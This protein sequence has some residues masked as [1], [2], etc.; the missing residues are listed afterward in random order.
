MKIK[1]SIILKD[2]GI[3][4]SRANRHAIVIGGS[5]AGLTTARILTDHYDRVTIFE[6]DHMPENFE[7]RKGVPQG[8]HP[9]VILKRG[10]N[11]L[12]ELFPGLTAE[13][14]ESGAVKI[15]MGDNAWFAFG[16]WRPRYESKIISTAASRPLLE[17]SVRRRLLAHPRVSLVQD[18]EVVEIG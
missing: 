2:E 16:A 5:I 13:L 3:F 12:E 15:N 10:E 6:R 11:I 14:M 9:H 4:N 18:C 17:G 1:R 7:N 8:R